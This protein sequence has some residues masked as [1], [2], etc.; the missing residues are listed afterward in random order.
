MTKIPRI[1]RV[2]LPGAEMRAG[3]YGVEE[4][5]EHVNPT[6][7]DQGSRECPESELALAAGRHC[8]TGGSWSSAHEL[9]LNQ[10]RG[11]TILRAPSDSKRLHNVKHRRLFEYKLHSAKIGQPHQ[12]PKETDAGHWAMRQ[13]LS[14]EHASPTYSTHLDHL[15]EPLSRRDIE[16]EKYEEASIF[17]PPMSAQR[18]RP[19]NEEG[20]KGTRRVAPE[21]GKKESKVNGSRGKHE[22]RTDAYRTS[23]K[24]CVLEAKWNNVETVGHVRQTR[25]SRLAAAQPWQEAGCADVEQPA[26]CGTASARFTRAG[27]LNGVTSYLAHVLSWKHEDV[28]MRKARKPERETEEGRKNE[29]RKGRRDEGNGINTLSEK[30]KKEEYGRVEAWATRRET[31]GKGGTKGAIYRERLGVG[32]RLDVK[33]KEGMR[34]NARRRKEDGVNKKAERR[35]GFI[36]RQTEHPA[37]AWA[38]NCPMIFSTVPASAMRSTRNGVGGAAP[39]RRWREECAFTERWGDVGGM[40]VSVLSWGSDGKPGESTARSKATLCAET[41]RLKRDACLRRAVMEPL[42]RSK[43]GATTICESPRKIQKG[44]R[45]REIFTKRQ[46]GSER[47]LEMVGKGKVEGSDG[48]VPRRSCSFANSAVGGHVLSLYSASECLRSIADNA[49][50]FTISA[51]HRATCWL[52]ERGCG[53]ILDRDACSTADPFTVFPF[54]RKSEV[55]DTVCDASPTTSRSVLSYA[56]L[57][58]NISCSVLGAFRAVKNL[59]AAPPTRSLFVRVWRSAQCPNARLL[60]TSIQHG[61]RL[62]PSPRFPRFSLTPQRLR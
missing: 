22:R 58:R 6:Q 44:S 30:N 43:H 12:G 28:R 54:W 50:S 15:V 25:E 35:R 4:Q 52:C 41:S 46:G 42:T 49:D 31:P 16:E 26:E 36:A 61:A 62:R 34:E 19:Q 53:R 40:K 48:S 5:E 13:R 7:Q 21:E 47:K 3:Y 60:T 20:G 33:V 39:A 9:L 11:Y 56:L 17:F 55:Q 37:A 45:K 29:K 8:K 23:A 59:R 32:K 1:G 18:G 57:R 27:V 38:G 14:K 51:S 10:G 24:G 2:D